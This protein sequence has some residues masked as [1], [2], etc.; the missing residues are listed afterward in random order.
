MRARQDRL[1]GKQREQVIFSGG[2]VWT[3]L[4]GNQLDKAFAHELFNVAELDTP[5]EITVRNFDH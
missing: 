3:T 2:F 5:D 1:P 4:F